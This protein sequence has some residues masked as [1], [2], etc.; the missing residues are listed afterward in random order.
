[1]PNGTL[2]SRPSLAAN[3][4]P[5]YEPQMGRKRLP[6]TNPSPSP[7]ESFSTPKGLRGEAPCK[8]FGQTSGMHE[9][10]LSK[11]AGWATLDLRQNWADEAWLRAHLAAAGLRVTANNEPAT[12]ARLKTLLRRSGVESPEA[13]ASVG[14]S[15]KRWLVAN[16]RLPLWVALAMVL[17]ATGRFT[18]SPSL[19]DAA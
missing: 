17:E 3:A 6:A 16:P 5:P 12:V 9:A 14:M 10:K 7:N 15:L 13:Q 4:Q 1:M 8:A 19:G 11:R 18:P 2:T